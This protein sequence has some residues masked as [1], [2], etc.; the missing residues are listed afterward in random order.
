MMDLYRNVRDRV[1]YEY[2][3]ENNPAWAF[4][5]LVHKPIALGHSQLVM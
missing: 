2:E 4:L 5:F 1:W 3:S